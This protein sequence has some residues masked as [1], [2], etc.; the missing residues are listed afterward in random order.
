MTKEQLQM[1]RRSLVGQPSYQ[2]QLCYSRHDGELGLGHTE[3]GGAHRISRDCTWL[4]GLQRPSSVAEGSNTGARQGSTAAA[5]V[6]WAI[7]YLVKR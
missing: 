1:P 3:D 2:E 7:S 4:V 6:K 5:L